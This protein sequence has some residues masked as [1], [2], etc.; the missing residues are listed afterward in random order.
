MEI[1]RDKP[2]YV[3]S[4]VAE[5]LKIPPQTL[6]I[7]EKSAL[8]E[9]CRSKRNT[10]LYSQRDVE[11]LQS[12]VRLH[13]DL[14]I[15]LAGIEV[16]LHMKQKMEHMQT[17]FNSLIEFVRDRFGADIS[18]NLDENSTDLVPLSDSGAYI[19][20]LIDAHL[21]GNAPEQPASMP[22]LSSADDD[23]V[24]IIERD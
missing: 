8:I 3:I 21:S 22:S 14:G 10:R 23:D 13:Q 16:I 9:P 6:R 2:V 17:E 11:K 18:S 12:I 15:N 24:I 7:Y 20:R 5:M 1:D 4:V 19:M